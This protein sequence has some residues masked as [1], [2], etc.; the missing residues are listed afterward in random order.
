MS[1]IALHLQL[2]QNYTTTTTCLNRVVGDTKCAKP[3]HH[4]LLPVKAPQVTG[5][6]SGW[7]HSDSDSQHRQM[8]QALG[9]EVSD[10]AR[11]GPGAP[12]SALA[13]LPAAPAAAQLTAAVHPLRRTQNRLKTKAFPTP[14]GVQPPPLAALAGPAPR[15]RWLC[16]LPT[17]SCP[18]AGGPL[19]AGCAPSSRSPASLP[20]NNPDPQPCPPEYLNVVREKLYPRSAMLESTPPLP[21]QSASAPPASCTRTQLAR[22]L[23]NSGA[24]REVAPEQ[25]RTRLAKSCPARHAGSW[26]PRAPVPVASWRAQ[27]TRFPRGLSGRRAW[28]LRPSRLAELGGDMAAL[29]LVFPPLPRLRGLLQRCW[30]RLEGGLLPGFSGGQSPPWGRCWLKERAESGLVLSV[31]WLR[32]RKAG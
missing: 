26:S 29:V 7:P 17:P 27:R 24:Y 5:Q 31:E 22:W 13:S 32:E 19:R 11:L 30:Q 23:A 6:N 8:I 25:R 20:A 16:K 28:A 15:T 14:A 2:A 4:A 1:G 3:L 21:S 10:R 18:A 9:P 12:T